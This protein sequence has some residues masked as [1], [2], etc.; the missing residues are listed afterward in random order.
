MAGKTS[1]DAVGTT[2]FFS[3]ERYVQ[4]AG[5]LGSSSQYDPGTY[6]FRMGAVPDQARGLGYTAPT[7]LL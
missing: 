6:K 4:Q 3:F 1:V 7:L 2:G 5:L